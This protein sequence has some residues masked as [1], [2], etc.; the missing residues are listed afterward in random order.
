MSDTPTPIHPKAKH[1]AHAL[2]A[3]F[4][5]TAP[6]T[7]TEII[8][9]MRK[10][11][12]DEKHPIVLL[13]DTVLDGRTRLFCALEADVEPIFRDFDPAKDGTPVQFV[14]RENMHRRHM[15]PSQRAAAAVAL[16]PFL[17]ADREAAEQAN[18][19]TPPPAEAPQGATA[20]AAATDETSTPSDVQN[21]TSAPEPAA[22]PKETPKGRLVDTAAAQ[23][24]VS[25]ANVTK[26]KKIEKEAPDLYKKI[27]DG[28]IT[29]HE[30][31]TQLAE[32]KLS[33]AGRAKHD[34]EKTERA[35]ALKTI[36]ATHGKSSDIAT[37]AKAK[38]ILKKH[39]DFLAFSTLAKFD[40]AKL[41]PLLLKGWT[42][43]KAQ[44]FIAG[45]LTLESS[46][47]DL[48]DKAL[49]SENDPFEVELGGH[50]ITVSKSV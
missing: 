20:Q 44:T 4:P 37:A 11:G 48:I 14:R 31:T 45:K 17:A 7:Q 23:M 36:E 40:A 22:T 21:P 25:A 19:A 27:Q 39:D 18:A 46:I 41:F 26:A 24:N 29:V 6:D 33:A 8:A 34:K 49:H 2:A 9:D 30:A 1:S 47:Q 50:F 16:M 28:L 3:L 13:D 5:L 43:Q 38:K 12:F 32:R 10:N 35:E 42:L 15:S